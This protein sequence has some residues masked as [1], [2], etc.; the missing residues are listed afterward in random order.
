MS[1]KH[2]PGQVQA[3]T[4]RNCS[5]LVSAAAGS[6]KTYVLTKR[7]LAYVSDETSP[8]DVDRF[9]IITFTRAAAAELRSRIM[10]SLTELAAERP[11]DARLRRQQSLC[12]Q[13]TIGTIH[14]FCTLV[15]REYAQQLG[16]SPAFSVLENDQAEQLRASVLSRL[17]DRRYENIES[18]ADFRLLCNTVGEGQNDKK[19][20]SVLLNLYKKLLSH[21]YPEVWVEEQKSALYAADAADA[22]DTPWGK[23]LLKHAKANADYWIRAMESA[24]EEMYAADDGGVIAAKYGA[25]FVPVAEQLR[26]LRRAMDGG[27]DRAREF[28]SVEF[29]PRLNGPKKYPDPAFMARMKAVW[30]GCKDACKTLGETFALNSATLLRDLRAAAPA[31]AALLDLT[32]ELDRACTAEKKRRNALD[33]SD[34]EHYTAQLLV[35]RETGAPTWV[36]KELSQRYQE[37]MVDEYQDVNAVQEMIFRAVSRDGNNLFMVGDVKQS[38]YRFR[39]ADPTLFLDKYRSYAPAET[40][41]PGQ[42]CRILLQENFRSRAPVLDA[43]NLVMRSI[44]SRELGE[45]DYDDDAALKYGASDYDRALDLPAEFHVIDMHGAADSAGEDE[46]PLQAAELEARFVASKILSMMREHTPVTES[47]GACRPC[48]WGDFVIL[49][50]TKAKVGTYRRVLEAAGIPVESQQTGDFFSSL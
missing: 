38:I 13:T 10:D 28:C 47:G 45:L 15:L 34:L 42:P 41:E 4:S 2:T 8:V 36:A 33:F 24:V 32:L 43:A 18:D 6:G 29:P 21:P 11:T 30:D 9:L 14:S 44:M 20:E 37:I 50:R 40:A 22:A 31:M 5:L 23:E 48:R 35:D 39:L 12:C 49:M 27:W 46:E 7:L 26:D 3:I 1:H 25:C 17:L 16:L 19:L